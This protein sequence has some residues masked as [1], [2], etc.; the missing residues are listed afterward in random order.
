M[1]KT[2]NY[3]KMSYISQKGEYYFI[4][5]GIS[6]IQQNSFNEKIKCENW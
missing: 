5:K 1:K 2:K 3:I 4:T 6:V